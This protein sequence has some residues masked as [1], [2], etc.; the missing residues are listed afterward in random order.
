MENGSECAV[1][2]AQLVSGMGKKVTKNCEGENTTVMFI[3]LQSQVD[4]WQVTSSEFVGGS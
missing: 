2:L 3:S 4:D 1:E